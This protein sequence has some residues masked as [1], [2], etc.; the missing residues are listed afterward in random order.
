LPFSTARN[1][2]DLFRVFLT[3]RKNVYLA[4]ASLPV[5]ASVLADLDGSLYRSLQ[6]M[7]AMVN[8]IKDS[9]KS[10]VHTA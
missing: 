3:T 7:S 5:E 8:G 10:E 9:V 1:F 2:F 4:P 6:N